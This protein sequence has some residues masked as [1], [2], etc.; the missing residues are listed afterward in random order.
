MKKILLCLFCM[1]FFGNTNA[2][3]KVV[4]FCSAMTYAPIGKKTL[5]MNVIYDRSNFGALQ[6]RFV[7]SKKPA[8]SIRRNYALMGDLIDSLKLI[9]YKMDTVYVLSTYYVPSGNLSY[10]YK[11][12]KDTFYLVK[13]EQKKYSIHYVDMNK[14]YTAWQE[15]QKMSDS[16]LYKVI[17]SWNIE[18]LIQRIKLIGGISG[19]EYHMSATRIILKNNQITSKEVVYFK[20]SVRWY[21]GNTPY[22]DIIPPTS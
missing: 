22:E 21:P 9:D 2:Q 11:T 12:Q 15:D 10:I 17:F 13:D 1:L 18:E 8:K 19:S 4:D 5:I 6:E 3:T 16:I 14:D 20:P 7:K